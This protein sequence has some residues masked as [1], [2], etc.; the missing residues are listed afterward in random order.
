VAQTVSYWVDV[1]PDVA[2]AVA[3]FRVHVIPPDEAFVEGPELA[4]DLL[5]GL[6][7]QA[8]R[9]RRPTYGVSD[10]QL[11]PYFGGIHALAFE[12]GSWTGAADPRR[13]GRVGFAWRRGE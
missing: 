7:E 4:P 10:S 3:A 13:D 9:L 8:F 2:S 1:A 12:Q 6:A 11:D 5:A